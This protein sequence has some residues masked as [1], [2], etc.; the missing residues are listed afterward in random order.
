MKYTS[1][2]TKRTAQTIPFVCGSLFAA[3]SFLYLYL[4]QSD[5]LA[6]LQFRLSG[7]QT[8]YNPL[9]GA[10][11]ITFVLTLVGIGL[12]CLFSLPIRALVLAWLPP[13]F[14]LLILTGWDVASGT[15]DIICLPSLGRLI[16]LAVLVV[17]YLLALYLSHVFRDA[18][19][20]RA[21]FSAH[22]TPN[23]LTLVLAFAVVGIMGNT[24]SPLQYEL[25]M[26]RLL[27]AER[28]ADALEVGEHALV[29]S[30][31]LSAMRCYALSREGKLGEQ[32]F[33]YSLNR[34]SAQIL[35]SAD[36]PVREYDIV[37]RICQH[38]G[39]EPCIAHSNIVPYLENAYERDTLASPVLREYLLAAL[40][41]ERRLPRV[42]ELL[43]GD[44]SATFPTHYREALMLY[45]AQDTTFRLPFSDKPMQKALRD[46]KKEMRRKDTPTKPEDRLRKHYARTYWYYYF[47]SR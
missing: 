39:V 37:P 47:F 35:P 33:A 11:L 6:F 44:S 13:C 40:L 7:G 31:R 18:T 46:F 32:L 9:V 24:S 3:F 43:S 10:L 2:N 34:G 20:E 23:L 1:A 36:E 5:L 12:Q 16:L 41:L 27:D 15:N 28:C 38:I 17:L 8:H 26:E 42:A 29:T 30:P 4:L 25:E 22:L 21:M 14:L 45:A 19:S